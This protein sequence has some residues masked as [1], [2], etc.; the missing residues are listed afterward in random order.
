MKNK[1]SRIIICN[2]LAGVFATV[3]LMCACNNKPYVEEGNTV[4]F[5]FNDGNSR[6]YAVVAENNES[7]DQPDTPV[8]EGYAFAGWFTEKDGKGTKINFPYT[9]SG[10]ET[11]YAA[12]AAESYTVTLDY[13]YDEKIET[14]E[15]DYGTAFQKPESPVREN[16]TLFS[17]HKDTLEGK[18]IVFPLTVKKDVKL[19]A[20]WVSTA[21]VINVGFDL[22]YEGAESIDGKNIVKGE[23]IRSS[24]LPTL[25]RTGYKLKGWSLTP[26]GKVL[27][28]PYTPAE[29]CT[30]YAIWKEETYTIVFWTNYVD[31]NKMFDTKTSVAGAPIEA[32]ATEPERAGYSFA[33]WYASTE[34]G[35][36]IEFPY[37][38]T[39]D[40]RIYAHWKHDPITTDIFQAEY[41]E[42][43]PNELFPGYSGENRGKDIIGS[44]SAKN[45]LIDNNFP[46]SNSQ[47]ASGHKG[48]YVT[49]LYKRGATLSFVIN[50]S[51]D[52]SN[53]TLQVS[54][55]IEGQASA[56]FGPTGDNAWKVT[57]NGTELNYTPFS[58]SIPG[59]IQPSSTSDFKLFTLGN[60]SLKK[61]ENIIQ[62]ITD[63]D[64]SVIGGTTR[65]NAPMVDYIKLANYGSASLSW[66][67][68]YD[69][70]YK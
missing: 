36:K 30:L 67:P 59:T 16:F 38:P 13:N 39:K 1:L 20:N 49:Y 23:T 64:H 46:L 62:L 66:S 28:F 33:G 18:E 34:G 37:S 14:E 8:R 58:L 12:W 42:L 2:L 3:G 21:D 26:N 41:V 48:Y 43:D 45:I 27:K 32:P 61:G 17:W 56:T 68:V 50:S 15:V 55:A 60:I 29:S 70:L 47:L 9:A 63:N 52:V 7:I 4:K 11:L 53:A 6:P 65:A 5:E 57:V 25:T 54:A 22:N 40:T 69:N 31:N 44:T 35:E 24:E 51:E 19:V 10:D